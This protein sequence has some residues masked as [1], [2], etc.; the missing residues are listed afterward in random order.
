MPVTALSVT[1]GTAPKTFNGKVLGVLDDGI[2]PGLDMVMVKL[3]GAPVTDSD[4][5]V[6]KGIWAGMSGSPVYA[7]DGRLIGAVAYGLSFGPDNV[8]GVTPAGAMLQLTQDPDRSADRRAAARA[9]HVEIAPRAA[10]SSGL[11]AKQAR[12]GFKRLPMPFSVSGL[13]AS[14]LA[15]VAKRFDINRPLVAGTTATAEPSPPIVPGG[16]LVASLSYGDLTYAGTGTATAVCDNKV[17]GFG[18]PLL[19]S[20]GSL[21]SMHNADALYIQRDPVF[22]SFKVANPTA[23]L[24]GVFQDRLAGVVGTNGVF[25]RSTDVTSH[26]ESTEGNARNG[27]TVVTYRDELPFLAALHLVV[28]ADRVLDQLGDGSA[29]VRWTVQGTR[30]DGSPWQYTRLNSFASEWD[31]TFESIFESYAQLSQILHNRFEKVDITDIH[32]RATYDPDYRALMMSKLETRQ[33]GDWVTINRKT[34]SIKVKPDSELRLRATLN[35]SDRSE[36]SQTVRLSVPV[37][38]KARNGGLFVGAGGQEFG[39]RVRA[40]SFEDLLEGLANAPRNDELTAT[41][42]TESR[43]GN[44]QT[45]DS[46][47]LSDVVSGGEFVRVKILD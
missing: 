16:N 19:W 37:P 39:G 13:S 28:N 20:G 6:N 9:R 26:V 46:Q 31:I 8:A 29:T 17:V 23:P 10:A 41:L 14:R 12:G 25:P 47:V 7:D 42:F 15:Q 35:P 45:S 22:G 5:D 3:R 11:T 40:S 2:A 18:H 32:Y 34:R 27:K 30:A 1:H 21:Y 43:K 33:G 44:S 36:E 38:D 4:G 24:G